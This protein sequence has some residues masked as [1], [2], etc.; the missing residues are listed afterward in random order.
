MKE[1]LPISLFHH[2]IDEEKGKIKSQLLLSPS[3]HRL[4]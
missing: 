2:K 4:R 1:Q 3:S